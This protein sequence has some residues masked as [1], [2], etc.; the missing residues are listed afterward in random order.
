MNKKIRW[1]V[2]STSNIAQSALIPAIGKSCNG[3]VVAIASRDESKA[4][5]V[6]GRLGIPKVFGSY[7]ALI[8]DP[9]VD[10]IYNPLPV[11][12]HAEWSLRCAEAGKPVLCEK[13]L[14]ANSLEA[15]TMK[16]EFARRKLLLGEAIM[17]HFHPL[18]RQA[19]ALVRSGVVGRVRALHS[20]FHVNIT[21]GD[22]R[23]QKNL[24]GGGLLDVG[25]YCV[26]VM[27]LLAGEEPDRVAG[28]NNIGVISQVDETFQGLLHFPSGILGNFSC[29][30]R[31]FFDCN[32][33]ISGSKG[34]I[35]VDAGAMC[36]WPG[37][38]FKIRVWSELESPDYRE[39]VVPPANPY[40]LL[41]EDFADAL[42]SK[43]PLTVPVSESIRNLK[44]IDRLFKGA[45]VFQAPDEMG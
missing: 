21:G 44:V 22:I 45:R 19:V 14:A 13:P 17:Y 1:G 43:R 35:L 15:R 20:T 33:E 31:T 29:G 38:E 28:F 6:A 23:F 25:S 36:A 37:G 24:G 12:M 2:L 9:E 8:Q 40:V 18:T 39:I 26:S 4:R 7:E 27:R 16:K 5:E 10:A 30:L 34:R 32:Y 11:A 41:V 42:L 3:E